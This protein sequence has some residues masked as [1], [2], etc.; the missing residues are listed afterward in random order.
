SGV[1]ERNIITE[2]QSG[3]DSQR[4][5]YQMLKNQFLRPGDVLVLTEFDRLGRNYEEIKKE[6]QEL[7]D[8]GVIIRF[9][10]NAMLGTYNKSDLE[11]KL[12]A[13]L[14]FELLAYISEKERLKIRQRCNEGIQNAKQQGIKFG[15][16]SIPI[17][18]NWNE[19]ISL[20]KKGEI[21]AV[22]AMELTKLKRTTF[23]KLAK[24]TN[25]AEKDTNGTESY[26]NAS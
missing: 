25:A 5:K 9:L 15:R 6:Y 12:I 8:K 24:Q 11:K 2:K 7:T 3:K 4:P 20:W 18:S 14:M 23:Y 21:T 19:V 17:P 16:P 22:K 10:E 26:S 13:N 1:E